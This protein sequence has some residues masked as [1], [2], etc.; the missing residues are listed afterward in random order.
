MLDRESYIRGNT[1]GSLAWI[2]QNLRDPEVVVE[3]DSAILTGVV[4][5]TVDVDGVSETF[6]L[7]LTQTWVRVGEAWLCIAGHAG[8]R[9]A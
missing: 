9:I 7:R 1:D 6:V 8:P 3:G 4:E 2:E 5:D